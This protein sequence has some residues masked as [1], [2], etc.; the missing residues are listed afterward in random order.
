M[1]RF[2]SLSRARFLGSV[3]DR[4]ANHPHFPLFGRGYSFPF[5]AF[6]LDLGDG[7]NAVKRWRSRKCC[8]GFAAG[9]K[10]APSGLQSVSPARADNYTS[11]ATEVLNSGLKS[12]KGISKSV[13]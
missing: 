1:V 13:E 8:S 10:M 2:I 11:D 12:S 9:L 6:T 7:E 3:I 5:H 4:L